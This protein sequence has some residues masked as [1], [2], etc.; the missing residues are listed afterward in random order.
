MAA[1]PLAV[2]DLVPI[3]SGSTAADALRNSVDLAQRA[4]RRG[5]H[6]CWFADRLEVLREATGAD[7]LVVTTITHGP[8]DRVRSFELLAREWQRRAAQ[9]T[10]VAS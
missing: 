3:P 6:R 1:T 2:L 10:G 5:Y 4:E 9:P 7:E 8:A